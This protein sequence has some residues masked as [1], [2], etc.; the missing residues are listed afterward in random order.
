MRTSTFT[1]RAFAKDG[2]SCLCERM[3]VV[4]PIST[5]DLNFR[6]DYF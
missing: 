1:M 4:L 5:L 3:A 6:G 2:E